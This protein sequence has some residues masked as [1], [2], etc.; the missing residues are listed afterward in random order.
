M[1]YQT[2]LLSSA[3]SEQQKLPN[4]TAFNHSDPQRYPYLLLSSARKQNNSQ[5]DIL[6]ACPQSVLTLNADKTLSFD[7][8]T[9]SNQLIDADSGFFYQLEKLYQ[10]EKQGNASNASGLPFTGGW[11]VYLAY[12]MAQEI[13]P[14][15]ALPNLPDTQPLAVAAR[16]PAAIIID[17]KNKQ[18]LAVAETKYAYL[19]DVIEQ[20]YRQLSQCDM[21]ESKIQLESLVE[22]EE[23]LYLN[24]VKKIKQYILDG[25]IFQ[26]NLSRLWQAKLKQ[27]IGDF[28]LLNTLARH[29]PS[30]FAAMAC[31]Q[32]MT[33]I[34]S[35]PERLVS[36]KNGIVETRP[37]A[38]TRPRDADQ[39]SDEA[40]A[41]ELL[42]HPKEQAE[43]IMLIDLER[44]D[45][46]RVCRPGSIEVNEL[47]TLESWQHV[48]HIVSNVR[49]ELKSDKSPIDVLRAVFP[50]G[51]ITGCPKVRCIEILAELEQQARGAYTGSLGYINRNGSMDFNIL[52]RTMVREG[53]K[54]TF[55][56]G[57]GIVNDSIA[58]KEL[59]ETRAKAKGLLKIFQ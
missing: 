55:R 22:S 44:N 4:L 38:G 19:L 49:G 24:Q 29:N 53:D 15:L 33:I 48:H 57:G 35:S 46:G 25:D 21:A 54:I 37:I 45:L 20:D 58:E 5:F 50:G 30:S 3:E 9:E 41:R 39:E 52:I 34:S 11:F 51:T 28:E 32:N 31:L 56:A 23:S 42:A 8:Q 13:E 14:R 18:C 7:E 59:E 1:S 12:E 26:A 6:I 10:Q 16:C 47:M 40:L 36:L 27:N 43:H 2:R 17:K